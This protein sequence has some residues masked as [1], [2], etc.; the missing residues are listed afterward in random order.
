MEALKFFSFLLV[1]LLISVKGFA[2]PCS[3]SSISSKF[4]LNGR[5]VEGIP[6][7]DVVISNNCKCAQSNVVLKCT[8]FSTIVPVDPAVFQINGDT[9]LVNSGKP[10]Q[11]GHPI[12]FNIVFRTPTD[13]KPLSSK[14]QC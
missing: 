6:Q 12:K 1:V 4:T 13:L 14:I 10:I 7:W 5:V 8:G 2:Q 9:C 11:Q 3:L